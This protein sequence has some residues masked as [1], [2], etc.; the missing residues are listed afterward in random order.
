MRTEERSGGRQ[1][2]R[3]RVHGRVQGVGYRHWLVRQARAL[4]VDG[5]VRN[6][7]DGTVE[8]LIAGDEAVLRELAKRCHEGPA[9]A[10]VER[11]ERFSEPAPPVRGFEQRPS[12]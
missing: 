11:V 2:L 6:R 1:A 5:W 3:L 9:L 10:R 7:A 8:A 4:G 12:R